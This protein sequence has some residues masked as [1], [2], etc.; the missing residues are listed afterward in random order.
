MPAIVAP[1]PLRP[2]DFSLRLQP[3]GT[4]HLPP[5]VVYF[6]RVLVKHR[7]RWGTDASESTLSLGGATRQLERIY[8][9]SIDCPQFP[10]S[11]VMMP[12]R[13]QALSIDAILA[14]APQSVEAAILRTPHLPVD[15]QSLPALSVPTLM[16]SAAKNPPRSW[17]APEDPLAQLVDDALSGCGAPLLSDVIPSFDDLPEIPDEEI[18]AEK[19]LLPI[20]KGR[21]PPAEQAFKPTTRIVSEKPK[22]NARG[23]VKQYRSY[24]P[25]AQPCAMGQTSLP[26]I[27]EDQSWE[28]SAALPGFVRV[29]KR[30][31][32]KK[33]KRARRGLQ[34]STEDAENV[35]L[36]QGAE[37]GS[38]KAAKSLYP[39]N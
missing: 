20:I 15:S 18:E 17:T 1:I 26:T 7:R 23:L 10:S 28:S 19:T 16:Y 11:I 38:S 2:H 32:C 12:S 31:K 36:T 35:Q 27:L 21:L 30:K 22:R 4:V 9:P 24:K 39:L 8:S 13:A 14:S 37:L 3:S 6:N 5:R 29:Y 33:A 34:D 25:K